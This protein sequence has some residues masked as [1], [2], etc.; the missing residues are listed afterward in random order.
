MRILFFFSFI[1][2][3]NRGRKRFVSEGD[4]GHIKPET[5]HYRDWIHLNSKP[6]YLKPLQ[7]KT[8]VKDAKS[9]KHNIKQQNTTKNHWKTNESPINC[10]RF[11]LSRHER[12]FEERKNDSV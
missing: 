1:L 3:L 11:S 12:N 6:I 4:G 7:K 2:F 8:K 9:N 5:L 10:N